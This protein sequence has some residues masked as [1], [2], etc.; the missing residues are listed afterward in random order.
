MRNRQHC[1]GQNLV[2]FS[3]V[4]PILTVVMLGI[5]GSGFTYFARSSVDNATREGA[6]YGSIH[7]TDVSGIQTRVRQTVSGIDTS[8]SSFQVVVSYPDGDSLPTERI[9]VSVTYPLKTFWPGPAAG[10]YA[11]AATMR[12]EKQ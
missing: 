5:V 4:L 7:P 2:E 12:I 6:R 1:R 3:L 11:T 9:R 8:S 10:T